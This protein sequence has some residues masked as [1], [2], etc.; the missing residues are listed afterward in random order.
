MNHSVRSKIT[1]ETESQEPF[2][3]KAK[4]VRA[5]LLNN[6]LLQ[7]AMERRDVCCLMDSAGVE[8]E[9]GHPGSL[10]QSP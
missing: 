2:V 6:K 9:R 10:L 7:I 8:T 1:Y 5:L 4:R 3:D